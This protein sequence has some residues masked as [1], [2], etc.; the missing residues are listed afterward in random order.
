MALIF[1]TVFFLTS[2][3]TVMHG[4]KQD[5][6][7]SSKPVG[8]LVKVN[9]RT[10]TTP[11]SIK[12][13]RGYP[14]YVLQFEKEGYD[15]VTVKLEQTTD[16]WVWGNLFIGGIIGIAIDY[17]NGSAYELTPEK[18]EVVLNKLGQKGLN[19]NETDIVV[20]IDK[21]DL[22]Q[23]NTA[24]KPKATENKGVNLSF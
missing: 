13:D 10:V 15:S 4:P 22:R 16:G 21:D 11:G 6:F 5:I 18:K 12:L 17:S 9:D 8:V 1:T 20:F 2:C 7:V 24:S 23:K 3:A 19:K 14:S